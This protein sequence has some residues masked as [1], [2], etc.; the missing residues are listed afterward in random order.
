MKAQ[1]TQ[2]R[3]IILIKKKHAQ[4]LPNKDRETASWHR[5]QREEL[6]KGH[7]ILLVSRWQAAPPPRS[8]LEAG[9]LGNCPNP[10]NS[11]IPTYLQRDGDLSFF[12]PSHWRA[13]SICW[14]DAEMWETNHWG[15]L[16]ELWT[17]LTCP[18]AILIWK[19]NR[20]TTG[21]TDMRT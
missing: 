3:Q 19:S 12:F 15:Q 8:G 21:T 6:S 1:S 14:R 4:Q 2:F 13:W 17:P 9:E 16:G 20:D 18:D 10:Q 7:M 11:Q 5:L